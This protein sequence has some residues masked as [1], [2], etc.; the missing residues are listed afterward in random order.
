MATMHALSGC[1]LLVGDSWYLLHAP[2]GLGSAPGVWPL[3][4]D[5]DAAHPG[6]ASLLFGVGV[7]T[8][9]QLCPPWFSYSV[10]RMPFLTC[11]AMGPALGRPPSELYSPRG[12]NLSSSAE[13]ESLVVGKPV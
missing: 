4:P 13:S 1:C 5:G 3:S 2:A 7:W 9:T 12:F 8:L 10:P 6:P 11:L